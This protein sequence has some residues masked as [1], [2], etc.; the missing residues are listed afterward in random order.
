MGKMLKTRGLFVFL[1]AAAFTVPGFGAA[2]VVPVTN[3]SF[4]KPDVVNL[5]GGHPTD[6]NA[7]GGA[8]NAWAYTQQTATSSTP[9]Y[10]GPNA[11]ND[12]I[13][14]WTVSSTN[15]P[16]MLYGITNPD[17]A[18]YYGANGG[19]GGGYTL[20]ANTDYTFGQ[21]AALNSSYGY[22]FAD[23]YQYAYA[24]LASGGSVSMTYNPSDPN[25][26]DPAGT[27][28]SLGNFIPG[29][30]YTLTVGIGTA[31]TAGAYNYSIVLL[32]NGTPVATTS[33]SSPATSSGDWIQA[34][35]PYTAVD[36]GTMGIE[37]VASNPNATVGVANFDN[38]LFT[39]L[40]PAQ[41][42]N[43]PEP[44]SLGMLALGVLGLLR[45]RRA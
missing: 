24:N 26:G 7:A 4:E 8:Q 5:T 36:S 19:T 41:G 15:N 20:T 6:Q 32:D 13:P 40:G 12:A 34:A 27:G 39:D 23:G 25:T 33:G 11:V 21:L 45:H 10:Y 3:G 2:I 29:D 1:A 28:Q 22:A 37:L 42:P 44:A 31:L 17:S 16:G 38:V 18:H 35:V 9:H 30:S 14:Y 43:A